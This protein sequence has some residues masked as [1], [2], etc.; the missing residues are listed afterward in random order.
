[1]G[2]ECL[3]FTQKDLAK[4][5]ADAIA[6]ATALPNQRPEISE[7][8]YSSSRTRATER[9]RRG[10][11]RGQLG[12][13]GELRG[14]LRRGLRVTGER[15]VRQEH[16]ARSQHRSRCRSSRHRSPRYR[17]KSRDG[18][19]IGLG[20]EGD[21]V[22]Y[23]QKLLGVFPADG[24]FRS[25]HR[26]SGARLSSGLWRRR[27]RATASSGRRRGQRSTIWKTRRCRATTGC[28]QDQA[29]RI[30]DIAE[31]V[32]RSPTMRGRIAAYCRWVTPL[33]SRSALVSRQPG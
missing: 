4:K 27:V 16:S 20:D 25:D 28:R 21:D 30:V 13:R 8:I 33:A 6:K 17:R 23:V 31:T 32:A 24:R 15:A 18:E 29:R 10:C 9:A 2:T 12:G 1:M 7:I 14:K 5:V 11:I 26:R 3:Y 19:T 22:V